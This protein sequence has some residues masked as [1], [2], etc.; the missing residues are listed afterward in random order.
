VSWLLENPFPLLVIGGLASLILGFMWTKTGGKAVGIALLAVV[1][2][3]LGVMALQHFVV[4]ERE[5]LERELDELAVAVESGDVEE[6]VEFLHA[7]KDETI[8]KVRAEFPHYDLKSVRITKFDKVEIEEG[9]PLKAKAELRVVVEGR[10]AGQP[11]P[12]HRAPFFVE[13]WL[14]KANDRWQVLDY[15]H[16]PYHA[17][18]QRPDAR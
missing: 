17:A 6:I 15:K 7:S 12:D 13:L 5:V 8:A 9:T 1:G 18:I 10:Y 2:A 16:H 14:E 4:T 3:T 11:G